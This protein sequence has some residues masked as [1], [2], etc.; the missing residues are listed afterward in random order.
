[1]E[2]PTISLLKA[3]KIKLTKINKQIWKLNE[4]TSGRDKFKSHDLDYYDKMLEMESCYQLTAYL[5]EKAIASNIL[6]FSGD[7]LTY[8]HGASG[9][10]HRN[11]M[12]PYLLQWE[13][14]C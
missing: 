12:A 11:L 14:I 10:E 6:I 1:M 9:N 8:L 4:E 5:G 3:E 2:N 7:T 13:S